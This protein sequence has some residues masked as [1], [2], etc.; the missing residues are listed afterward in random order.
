MAYC[1]NCG[2]KLPEGAKFC[3]VCGTK[4]FEEASSAL[5]MENPPKLPEY[6]TI[7]M[8]RRPSSELAGAPSKI[9]ID[10][11]YL[12]DI[13]STVGAEIRISPGKHSVGIIIDQYKKS[14]NIEVKAGETVFLSHTLSDGAISF[15]SNRVTGTSKYKNISTVG[16]DNGAEKT[17]V[18]GNSNAT[19]S[20]YKTKCPNCGSAS[21]S[22]QTV[23]ESSD[24]GCFSFLGIAILSLLA[25]FLSVII[26]I[27]VFVIGLIVVVSRSKQT[28]TYAVCQE[29][30]HRF[31]KE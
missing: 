29:C 24:L 25:C 16:V 7:I 5:I 10:Q 11:K 26:G 20:S 22:Y 21:I 6:G 19:P 23:T 12:G 17:I 27:I 1:T 15:D 18:T 13:Y 31:R 3:H 8:A 2:S 30:G 9:Y 14:D 4:V 28:V